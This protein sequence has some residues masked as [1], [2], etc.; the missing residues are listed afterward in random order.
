MSP[1]LIAEGA[2]FCAAQLENA[3]SL[4]SPTLRHRLIV[5]GLIVA[6]AGLRYVKLPNRPGSGALALSLSAVFLL[7]MGA[8]T[9]IAGFLAMLLITRC[10]E[11]LPGIRGAYLAC[12]ATIALILVESYFTGVHTEHRPIIGQGM[13]LVACVSAFALALIVVASELRESRNALAASNAE[14]NASA[15]QAEEITKL[16]ERSRIARDLHDEIGHGLTS[17]SVL[18]ES[19]EKLRHT[20]P[21]AADQ[22]IA[23]ARTVVTETLSALRHTVSRLRQDGRPYQDLATEMTRLCE[24]FA[25][26]LNIEIS[27]RL[28][29]AIS[30]RAIVRTL[31]QIAREALTN[32]ARHAKASTVTIILAVGGGVVKVC[33]QD[34][35]VGFDPD[36]VPAGNGL[37]IMHERAAEIGG[38]CLIVSKPGMGTI[39]R[40]RLPLSGGSLD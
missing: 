22:S 35:G 29:I 26:T 6:F 27:S 16:E 15:Q 38:R 8:Y 25:Q 12:A 7:A 36:V 3:F 17:L 33:V 4:G 40:V 9:A 14:L 28:P 24:D 21:E 37:A 5:A 30:D 13:V 39:V 34:D 20:A 23:R 2:A 31:E 1:F 11:L 10:F 32:V 19:S 18:L